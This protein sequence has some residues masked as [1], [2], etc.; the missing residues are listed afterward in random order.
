[1]SELPGV[2]PVHHQGAWYLG[3]G[4]QS[5][6]WLAPLESTDWSIRMEEVRN[7]SEHGAAD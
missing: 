5:D 4:Q 2:F 1:M 7:L 3:L 6:L